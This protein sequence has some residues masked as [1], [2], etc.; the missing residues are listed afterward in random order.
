MDDDD[1]Q[2]SPGSFEERLARARSE[3]EGKAGR[4]AS[5]PASGLSL[6]F[7]L[8]VELVSGIAAGAILGWLLDAVFSTAPVMMVVLLFLGAAAGVRNAV[9]VTLR[10]QEA[11][12][13]REREG[14]REERNDDQS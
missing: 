8:S 7:R 3:R 11:L 1:R 10:Y 2:P 5:A 13:A 4:P 6:A 14:R 12:D 9:R